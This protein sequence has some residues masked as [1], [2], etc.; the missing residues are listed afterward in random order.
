MA[1]RRP[2]RFDGRQRVEHEF[3][4]DRVGGLIGPDHYLFRVLAVPEHC[5]LADRALSLA[6]RDP[7]SG[8]TI[9][10]CSPNTTA[11]VPTS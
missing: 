6:A 10:P 7:G 5:H 9:L 2:G 1:H 11:V 8:S 3:R 4:L